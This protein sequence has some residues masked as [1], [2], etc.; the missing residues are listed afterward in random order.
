MKHRFRSLARY[1]YGALALA[2]TATVALP[3]LS[4]TAFANQ[5]T[6]RSIQMSSSVVSATGVSYKVTFTAQTAALSLV[7]DFCQDTPIIGSTC[8][9]TNGVTFT[10]AAITGSTLPTGWAFGSTSAS[11]IKIAGTTTALSPSTSY[12]FTITGVNNPTG[13][14]STLGAAGSFYARL[15]TYAN[16]TYGTYA[17]ASSI[18]NDVDYGGFALSTASA[19]SI[20]AVVAEALTFCVSGSSIA[21]CASPTAPT[22]TIGHAVGGQTI[23]DNTAVDTANAYTVTATNAQSGVVVRMKDTNASATCGGLSSDSGTTCGIPAVGATTSTITAGTAAI[24]MCVTAGS[25]NTTATSP[26]N[27][28]GCTQYGLDQATANNNVLST[29]GSQIFSSSSTLNNETDT[30]KFAATAS[31]TTKAGVYTATYSLICTG[32]F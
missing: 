31:T 28:A 29:F 6:S 16:N 19:I 7:M 13:T 4:G 15:Y 14:S 25:A 1:V 22:I 11:M 2:I 21:T 23:L 10:S 5:V 26:Y 20:S 32:T 24:G 30:L 3:I 18:G 8:V 27:N 17:S 12:T 9:G